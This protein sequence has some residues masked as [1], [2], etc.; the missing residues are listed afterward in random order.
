MATATQSRAGDRWAIL[1]GL[2]VITAAAWIY[3]AV[4]A[5]RM[6]LG[7]SDR[8]MGDAMRPMAH[9]RMWT[10]TEFGLM[11]VMWIVMM[12][13]MMVPTAGP[14]TLVY[15]AVARKAAK[16][17]NP[18]APTFV[19]VAGYLT[20][21]SLFSVA[22]T[23]AQRSLDHFALLSPTMVSASPGLG[24][25]LLIGAGIYEL[26]RYK[27]ACLARC[28]APAQFI[29]QHWR[30]G[31]GGAFRMGFELGV[32][33]LGCCWMLM[34]LLFVGGVMNLLW[35]A[36]IAVFVLLEKT[37]PFAEMG[38]RVVGMAMV[39]VGVLSVAGVVVLG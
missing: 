6:S 14:M 13:A 25:A 7:M 27:Q 29:S 34:A 23:I 3:L 33:C 12:I 22:A 31:L 1:T 17:A 20:I 36:A 35:V 32:Y 18:V 37:M 4:D 39:L 5:R 24:G 10:G 38:G 30:G 16:Q 8:S 28:R 15:G 2:G 19:F 21:W 9:A 11:L 26:T